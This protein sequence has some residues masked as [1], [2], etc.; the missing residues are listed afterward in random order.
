MLFKLKSD[1]ITVLLNLA[2]VEKNEQ[3]DRLREENAWGTDLEIG[4][5]A[6]FLKLCIVVYIPGRDKYEKWTRFEPNKTEIT[7]HQFNL[8]ECNG[9]LYLKNTGGGEGIHY[10]PMY[11][12]EHV[13]DRFTKFKH[14]V[15]GD[16]SYAEITELLK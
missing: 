2:I 6:N 3:K 15:Y 5:I 16:K 13:E 11:P 4:L 7:N 10:E 8:D 14:P 12:K 1:L 9:I